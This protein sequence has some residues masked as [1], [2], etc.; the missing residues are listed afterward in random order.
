AQFIVDTGW[1]YF[2]RM[3]RHNG[4]FTPGL[5]IPYVF[6]LAKN[7]IEARKSPALRAALNAAFDNIVDWI[8][9]YPIKK[10]QSPLRLVPNYE[11]WLINV[12]Q[13]GTYDDYWQTA[14]GSLEKFIDDYPDIP[15][16]LLS[17]W[18]GHHPW[19]N[20]HKYNELRKRLKSPVVLQ[21]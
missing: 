9:A 19:G 10:G 4:C 3:T 12:S 8:K 20:F 11:N 18:Y 14:A 15:L 21:V 17:S 2:T 7:G 1:N 6:R 16:F 5:V 13:R